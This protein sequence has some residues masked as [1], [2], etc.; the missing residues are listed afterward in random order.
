MD[1]DPAFFDL[2]TGDDPLVKKYVQR[3]KSREG[4]GRKGKQHRHLLCISTQ[5]LHRVLTD[6]SML[7]GVGASMGDQ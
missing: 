7:F 4:E 2:I 1:E 3:E 6:P 5:P